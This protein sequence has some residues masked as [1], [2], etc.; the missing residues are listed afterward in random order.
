M[1]YKKKKVTKH[2]EDYLKDVESIQ[3]K[4]ESGKMI[5]FVVDDEMGVPE[6]L[7]AQRTATRK[8]HARYAFWAYQTERALHFVR[9]LE[10]ELRETEGHADLVYRKWYDEETDEEYTEGMVRARVS[11]DVTV[12]TASAKLNSARRQYGLLRCVRDAMEHRCYILRRL[13]AQEAEAKKG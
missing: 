6:D 9:K 7:E 2:G 10:K 12:T 1:S 4:L 13:L 11:T 8:A 5:T 3:V